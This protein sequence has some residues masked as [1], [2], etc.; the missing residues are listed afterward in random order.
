[1]VSEQ[2]EDSGISGN[3]AFRSHSVFD[4]YGMEAQSPS[5]ATRSTR[6]L[7]PKSRQVRHD[8]TTHQQSHVLHTR[9]P[10]L[11]HA[12]HK[13]PSPTSTRA[14]TLVMLACLVMYGFPG[15]CGTHLHPSLG[16]T[17]VLACIPTSFNSPTVLFIHEHKVKEVLDGELVGRSVRGCQ[18]V[19]LQEYSERDALAFRQVVVGTWGHGG[20]GGAASMSASREERAGSQ[21]AKCCTSG[22]EANRVRFEE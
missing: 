12:I 22:Q 11:N 21:A 4:H 3:T 5:R 17:R 7:T 8:T 20:T 9:L 6:P 10:L 19:R 16:P 15:Q 1:M 18:R 2:V 13:L 14:S